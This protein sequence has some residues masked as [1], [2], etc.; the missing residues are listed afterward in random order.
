MREQPD[1]FVSELLL[2]G[3]IVTS[4][5][6]DKGKLHTMKIAIRGSIVLVLLLVMTVRIIH[7]QGMT[8]TV[9]V[10]DESGVAI[11]QAIVCT[12]VGPN[13]GVKF[14][15]ANG[16]AVFNGLSAA[17]YG[18]FVIKSGFGPSGDNQ[19][20]GVGNQ[21]RNIT[22]LK[23][24]PGSPQPL[25]PNGVACAPPSAF[26]IP[27]PKITTFEIQTASKL[28]K[29]TVGVTATIFGN[30]T[31]TTN[32]NLRLHVE[33]DRDPS[34]FRVAEIQNI[35]NPEQELRNLP[36]QPYTAG[37]AFSFRLDTS[38][39]Y[40]TRYV[41]MQ[42][43]RTGSES[44]A[45]P[46]KGDSVILAPERIKT[47]TLT[48]QSLKDFINRATQLGYRFTVTGS[49]RTGNDPCP[50]SFVSGATVASDPSHADFVETTTSKLF[51]RAERFL[52]PFWKMSDIG[53]SANHAVVS[54]SGPTSGRSD[55]PLRTVTIKQGFTFSD[56]TGSSII[57]PGSAGSVT[58][59]ANTGPTP[60]FQTSSIGSITL[61]GPDDKQAVDALFKLPF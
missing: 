32:P 40:G 11:S 22:L 41:F 9:N 45:S 37:M 35:N 5:N 59:I 52:N 30:N 48:G 58:C 42:I 57:G 8:L 17:E 31:T 38:R 28:V 39:S 33:F 54:V 24:A 56:P 3:S 18:L 50:G 53:V 6:A 44:T 25:L 1:E 16:Q 47:F 15:D 19:V 61:E 46:A 21:T 12:A 27:N 55:D 60:K 36:W 2:S 23:L 34:F 29:P 43:S 4:K 49:S 10:K 51:D 7:G 20:Y 13:A 26:A 14:S